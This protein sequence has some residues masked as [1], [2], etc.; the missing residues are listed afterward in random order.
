ME[1]KRVEVKGEY[2]TIWGEEERDTDYGGIE[3]DFR[4]IGSTKG[5]YNPMP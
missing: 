4:Y 5:Q 3:R 1:K 2:G